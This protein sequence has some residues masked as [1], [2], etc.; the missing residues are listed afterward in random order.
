M[1]RQ[2]DY[3]RKKNMLMLMAVNAKEGF[4]NECVEEKQHVREAGEAVSRR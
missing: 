2:N 4:N 1:E 3:Q